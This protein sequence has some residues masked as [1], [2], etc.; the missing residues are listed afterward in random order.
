M[1]STLSLQ[2]ITTG[3][4]AKVFQ[5]NLGLYAS[6]IDPTN[7]FDPDD[8]N[9][10]DHNMWSAVDVTNNALLRNI[11]PID[12]F[13]LRSYHYAKTASEQTGAVTDYIDEYA[14]DT[15]YLKITQNN[16]VGYAITDA[17]INASIRTR[18]LSSAIDDY[19]SQ[20]VNTFIY[21]PVS[22]I[23]LSA[24]NQIPIYNLSGLPY[25]FMGEI[26]M[27]F[28]HFDYQDDL[29]WINS[30]NLKNMYDHQY[31]TSAIITQT[32]DLYANTVSASIQATRTYSDINTTGGITYLVYKHDKSFIS[33]AEV[34]IGRD[35][36]ST[37]TSAT[38]IAQIPMTSSI[39]T[40]G[41]SRAYNYQMVET[42]NS[43]NRY[44]NVKGHKSNLYSLN[45]TNT[46]LSTLPLSISTDLKKSI[47][48][49][50]REMIMNI[51]PA[52]TQLF[53]IYW[54][55]QQV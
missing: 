35:P 47:N 14:P 16:S 27:N 32:G 12:Q 40:S 1:S 20:Q 38:L 13:Y 48:N 24:E 45:I 22:A 3:L 25:N 54:E 33:D 23:A 41:L 19:V 9:Y 52:N 53:N 44:D 34:S 28:K 50:V 55:G 39:E 51:T 43:I 17:I 36:T 42:V 21:A 46:N 5:T 7:T 18:T 4:K 8:S 30:T 26:P 29:L 49:M 15:T 6:H 10:A 2:R 31:A 11:Y 37:P